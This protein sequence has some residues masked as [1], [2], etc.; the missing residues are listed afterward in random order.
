MIKFGKDGLPIIEAEALVR[1][2]LAQGP[3]W[4]RFWEGFSQEKILGTRC[5]KCG[6][7]LV[8]ARTFCPRCFIDMEEWVEVSQEGELAGW[9]LTE[10]EYFGMPTPAPFVTGV[11]NLYGADCSFMHLIGGIDL[12]S[13]EAVRK[14]VRN[15]M[16]VRAVWNEEKNGGI[17][18]IKYFEPAG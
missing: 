6:R 7:V 2:E 3:T 17:M 11:I 13:L 4:Q 10:I 18:D 9:S 16:R 1:Y 15:G 8:P 5:S 12:S 14:V